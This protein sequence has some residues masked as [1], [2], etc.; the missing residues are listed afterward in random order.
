M[1]KKLKKYLLAN[2]I[3]LFLATTGFS[4]VF[5][6]D[7]LIENRTAQIEQCRDSRN[8]TI[9]LIYRAKSER[10]FSQNLRNQYEIL[11][12]LESDQSVLTKRKNEIISQL[13]RAAKVAINSATVSQIQN[14]ESQNELYKQIENI[15]PYKELLPIIPKYLKIATDGIDILNEKII[16]S[17]ESIRKLETIK[18]IVLFFGINREFDIYDNID[19]SC[20]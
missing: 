1:K 8:R 3:V 11:S 13:K 19:N 20:P 18:N 6:F 5:I 10:D 15:G 16:D 4:S 9:R 17:K 14:I 12:K 2:G 7:Y